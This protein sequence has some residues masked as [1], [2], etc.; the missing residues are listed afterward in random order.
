MWWRGDM[1]DL[2]NDALLA[3]DPDIVVNCAG[4]TDLPWCEA[5]ARECIRCNLEEPVR[6]LDRV[7]MAFGDRVPMFHLSSGCVWDGP[8]RNKPRP[9][10][11][12]V[13]EAGLPT[14]YASPFEPDDPPTPACLYAWTKAACDSMLLQRQGACVVILRP[15]Q[16]YS[17]TYSPRNTLTKLL[18][19]DKLLDT[20]NSMTS[21]DTIA[22]TIEKLSVHGRR[23]GSFVV[24]VYDRGETSPFK[25]GMML[26]ERGLRKP[27]ALLTKGELDVWHKPKRVDAVIHDE[28][29]EKVVGP[30]S[31]DEELARNMDA[32]AKNMELI[33]T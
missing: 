30:P 27:P 1:A 28:F 15:R 24:N 31:V 12:V 20:P 7:S 5:N 32:F 9:D 8:Y 4:K 17:P 6:L 33:Q 11:W 13:G 2:W 18:N 22:K 29:F 16:V 14:E 21:A 19:Y 25:V 23:G 10:R 3:A 26:A